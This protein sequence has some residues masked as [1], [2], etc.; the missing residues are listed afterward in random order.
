MDEAAKCNWLFSPSA[1]REI[2]IEHISND[3]DYKQL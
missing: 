2:F 1:I 3:E